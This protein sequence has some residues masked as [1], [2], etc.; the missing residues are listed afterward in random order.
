MFKTERKPYVMIFVGIFKK[1][2]RN[3]RDCCDYKEDRGR[4]K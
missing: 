1:I 2:R 4:A 3:R